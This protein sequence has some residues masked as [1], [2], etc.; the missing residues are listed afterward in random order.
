MMGVGGMSAVDTL[1]AV[2]AELHPLV[3]MGIQ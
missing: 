3:K 2:A 1:V